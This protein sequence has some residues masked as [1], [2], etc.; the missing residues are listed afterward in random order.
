MPRKTARVSAPRPDEDPTSLGSILTTMGV[1]SEADLK[2]AVSKQREASPEEQ[3]GY[4]LVSLGACTQEQV[5]IA[6]GSK[7]GSV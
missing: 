1:I 2:R 3:L 7:H 6:T 4:I 5:H